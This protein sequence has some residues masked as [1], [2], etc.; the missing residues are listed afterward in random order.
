MKKP[1]S[2]YHW[3]TNCLQDTKW[4]HFLTQIQ[5]AFKKCQFC[6]SKCH[7]WNL[8]NKQQCQHSTSCKDLSNIWFFK[9]R[10]CHTW[11]KLQSLKFGFSRW[12]LSIVYGW[13]HCCCFD[14]AIF[15]FGYCSLDKCHR[16]APRDQSTTRLNGVLDFCF[17]ANRG[18]LKTV[19]TI[20]SLRCYR[21]LTKSTVKDYPLTIRV[22]DIFPAIVIS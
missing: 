9:N 12:H 5:N 8:K 1:F 19:F 4:K 14:G 21:S 10:F 18:W 22:D 11:I 15:S 7:L 13:P 17:H 20:K 3:I 2:L 16:E 6:A